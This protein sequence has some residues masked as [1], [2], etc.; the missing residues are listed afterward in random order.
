MPAE[1]R[2]SLVPLAL[3]LALGLALVAT[4]CGSSHIKPIRIGVIADCRSGGPLSD[5]YEL[6]LA[7]A[8]LPFV[9]R[10]AKLRGRSPSDGIR[11]ASISGKPVDL[12]IACS[13]FGS[14]RSMLEQLRSLVEQQKAN[15][16]VLPF[17]A[18]A[19]LVVKD[20]ARRHP[21]VIF[22]PISTEQTP[23]LKQPLANVFRFQPDGAQLV[24]GLGS[25]A[26]RTL[27]WRRVVTVGEYD[28]FGFSQVGGFVA[29]FCSLG[30]DVVQKLWA[31]GG[32]LNYAPVVR[33]IRMKGVDGVFF[34]GGVGG[35]SRSLAG[36]LA[37]RFPNLSRSLLVGGIPLITGPPPGNLVGVVGGS[38]F[39]FAPPPSTWTRYVSD[40]KRTFGMQ[41]N[42][43][44]VP[45]YVATDALLEALGRVHGDVSHGERR[46]RTA[47]ARLRLDTPMGVRTLDRRH[48]AITP[49][50]LSRIEK[51]A[52]GKVIIRRIR[53]V[54]NVEQTFSGYFGATSPV[55]S[56]TQPTCRH[57]NP[58]AWAR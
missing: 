53:V 39:P 21:G 31:D 1:P 29:E 8:E 40:L 4:G 47:L 52:T 9:D 25:Y 10:G 37:R 3:A 26:Y 45:F 57:G 22:I 49:I 32:L 46:L 55:P 54:S 5:E 35:G 44:E 34:P 15:A 20:Y 24:A 48:Q 7:G 2:A 27:G 33:Q 28:P 36:A 16:V 6:T 13:A 41:S 11:G 18:N 51:D 50:Y 43:A 56:E 19:G 23:T 17:V 14:W 12:L 38:E 58:P 42:Y 30:G